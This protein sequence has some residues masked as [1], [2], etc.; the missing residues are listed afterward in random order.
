MAM[1]VAHVRRLATLF[2]ADA[3]PMKVKLTP[4]SSTM[5]AL[6]N[7]APAT[8]GGDDTPKSPAENSSKMC[9]LTAVH[10]ITLWDERRYPGPG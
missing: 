8:E 6:T 3:K 5:K 2:K 1:I 7:V 10:K 9:F 4:R